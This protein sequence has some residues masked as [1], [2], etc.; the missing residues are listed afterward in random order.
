MDDVTALTQLVLH[1]RQGRDRGWWDQMAAA[2]APDAR[3]RISW[4]DGTATEFVT[5]SRAMAAG[6]TNATHRMGA[7]VVHLRGE[8]AVVEAPAVIELRTALDGAEVDLASRVRLLYTAVRDADGWRL[9]SLD[10]I[11]ESD[12]VT[13]TM[14]DHQPAVDLDRLAALRPSYRWL[15]YVL[16]RAGHRIDDD[17]PGEDR[18]DGVDR[19]YTDRFAWLEQR[20]AA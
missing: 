6:G 2:F 11:Y 12:T 13:A 16:D 17:M 7:A 14:P 4:I 18:P 3:V 10:C 1:E 15:A 19:L 5:G 9:A 20:S 8:R